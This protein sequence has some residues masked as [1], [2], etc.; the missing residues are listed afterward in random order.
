MLVH[1]AL[2]NKRNETKMLQPHENFRSKSL[3]RFNSLQS[4]RNKSNKYLVK[5]I[6]FDDIIPY[7]P[8]KNNKNESFTKAVL[9]IDIEGFEPFA[10]Q[11]AQKLLDTLDI[12]SIH[13]EWYTIMKELDEALVMP[14]IYMLTGKNY[15]PFGDNGIKLA[16]N[17]WK[18]GWTFN[19]EWRKIT[20]TSI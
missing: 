13:M 14:M 19:V 3:F 8:S 18:I 7:I 17:K 1:N 11:N 4:T 16:L 15:A 2:S 12:L 5:T 9:K 20:L 10:F 6:L